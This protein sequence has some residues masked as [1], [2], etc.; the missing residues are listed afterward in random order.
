MSELELSFFYIFA[1]GGINLY[2]KMR[3]KNIS[4]ILWYTQMSREF[5]G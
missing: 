1:V 2:V 5:S 3:K 4:Q